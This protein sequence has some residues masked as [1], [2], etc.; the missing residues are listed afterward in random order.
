LEEY[1]EFTDKF[2]REYV[3]HSPF[4][5]ASPYRANEYEYWANVEDAECKNKNF[6]RRENEI[7]Q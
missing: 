3:H 6:Y 4:T 5:F 7:Q 2:A 1:K